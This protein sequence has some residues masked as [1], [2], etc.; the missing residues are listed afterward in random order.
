[1]ATGLI[2]VIKNRQA[3]IRVAVQPASAPVTITN[4]GTASQASLAHS[5]VIQAVSNQQ[6]LLKTLTAQEQPHIQG[7]STVK[8]PTYV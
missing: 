8:K 6:T 2:D 5:E 1:M 4:T 3:P 7:I